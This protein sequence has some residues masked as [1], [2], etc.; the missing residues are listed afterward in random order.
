[1]NFEKQF[2]S[3]YPTLKTIARRYSQATDIPYEEYESALCE[4]FFL[5]H[6]DF[7]HRKNPSFE[8]YMRVRLTQRATRVAGR[9]ERIFYDNSYF[10][11]GQAVNE[12]GEEMEFELADGFC[13]EE[14]VITLEERK[15]DADKRELINALISNTDD[16]T[17]VIVQEYLRGEHARPTGIGRAIGVHHQTVR[18]KLNSIARNYTESKFGKLDAYLVV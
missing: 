10:Y 9:K 17:K 2:N 16:T 12:E 3:F 8:G 4:E 13:L 7:D 11:E 5:K 1:M 15:T 14:Y 18:R 6:H